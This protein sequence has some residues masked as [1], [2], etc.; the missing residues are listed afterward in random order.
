MDF[1]LDLMDPFLANVKFLEHH[2]LFHDPNTEF[3]AGQ[4]YKE[5]YVSLRGAYSKQASRTV[6]NKT[7]FWLGLP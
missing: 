5:A 2:Q 4:V 3:R 6:S 1:L 7:S